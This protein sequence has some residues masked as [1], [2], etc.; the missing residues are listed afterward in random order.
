MSSL[1]WPCRS[2]P[3]SKNSTSP[4]VWHTPAQLQAARPYVATIEAL[5]FLIG[6]LWN[7]FVLVSYSL[8]RKLL[9]E[10]ANIYLFNLALIDILLCIFI[11]LM[12]VVSEATGEFIFGASDFVRCNY[13]E[14]L[15][16]LLHTFI[17]LSLH[18][19]TALSV[20]RFILLSQPVRY[21]SIFNWKKALVLQI[22]LWVISILISVPPL[23]GFGEYEY[24]VVLASCNARWTGESSR[25]IENIHYVAFFGVEAIIPIIILTVTNVWVVKI[26]KRFLKQRIARQRTYRGTNNSHKIKEEKK[27]QHQQ[28]QLVKV[29]GAL[30]IAHI[31]CWT[32]VLTVMFV[33]LGIGANNIPLELFLAIWL[34]Y[35]TIP[36]IHPILESF[37][38]K[39][40]RHVLNRT[41]K[42]MRFSINHASTL[43]TQVS[44][45]SL[46]RSFS[47]SSR[48]SL[49]SDIRNVQVDVEKA[50]EQTNVKSDGVSNGNAISNGIVIHDRMELQG[51][52]TED[53]NRTADSSHTNGDVNV[54]PGKK[55]PQLQKRVSFE[56]DLDIKD[57][58]L[59]S[60]STLLPILAPSPSGSPPSPMPAA[61]NELFIIS[62]Q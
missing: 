22:S 17:S 44:N 38:I 57:A 8:K 3:I 24:N 21:K 40:L 19:V 60:P 27:Y 49:S 2:G 55:W 35:L 32:P 13:C 51:Y 37:F 12:S 36:V 16:V 45:T 34:I 46:M 1:H 59:S 62:E 50:P 52:K 39:D 9:K 31:V 28:N 30:F 5:L 10:P 18:T 14:F 48:M 29:F 42:T 23:F 11:T 33:A 61:T 47:R 53:S 4:F 26:V 15:G 43:Y 7:A 25:G 41:K 6:F 56:V 20:D 54:R 58:G